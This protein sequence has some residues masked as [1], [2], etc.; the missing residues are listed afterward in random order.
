[1]HAAAVL[2]AH[3]VGARFGWLFLPSTPLFSLRSATG[4][5]LQVSFA[6]GSGNCWRRA[7]VTCSPS[8]FE[9]SSPP[10][11]CQGAQDSPAPRAHRGWPGHGRA[12]LPAAPDLVFPE[13]TLHIAK[14]SIPW[15]TVE[16]CPPLPLAPLA[17]AKGHIP[18]ERPT[19]FLPL[20]QF[21]CTEMAHG[22]RMDHIN[23]LLLLQATNIH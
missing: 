13:C 12:P 14:P 17:Q 5:T 15:D 10:S 8:I 18:Y 9:A 1:M 22:Q 3:S 7:P 6:R 2:T 16:P 19:T 23:F 11:F 20:D 4:S 21:Y